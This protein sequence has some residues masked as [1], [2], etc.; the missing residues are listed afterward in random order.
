MGFSLLALACLTQWSPTTTV[1]C[2]TGLALLA[3]GAD[4]ASA[5]PGARPVAIGLA[6][7]AGIELLLIAVFDRRYGAP[8]FTDT[9]ALALYAYIAATAIAARNWRITS[10]PAPWERRAA[11]A[12]WVM[13]GTAVLIGGSVQFARFFGRQAR[14][15][16]DLA[17]SVWWLIYAGALVQL[18]FRLNR[19]DVR[20][21]GLGV[22]AV[23]AL[24]IVLYDLS[25]LE[26]LY[27]V[28]VF[29]A[30]ALIALAVAY[31]YNR[32]AKV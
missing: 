23:A 25:T 10:A 32:R 31:A 8:V 11:E 13:C 9:W 19:K 7:L 4:R 6:F 22:A 15:A 26:A 18:G 21:A 28:A 27:R 3:L 29:F 17:L 16:G 20:S 14:L 30:L 2:W 5:Q 1:F 24:K 12:F